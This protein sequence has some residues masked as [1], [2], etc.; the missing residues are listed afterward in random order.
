MNTRVYATR[1]LLIMTAILGFAAAQGPM[2]AG[3]LAEC[4]AAL[5]AAKTCFDDNANAVTGVSVVRSLPANFF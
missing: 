3:T 2:Y 1:F 5:T 4:V